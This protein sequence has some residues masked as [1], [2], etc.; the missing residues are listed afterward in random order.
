MSIVNKVKIGIAAMGLTAL[1]SGCAEEINQAANRGGFFT[2]NNADY[3]VIE[4]GI[5]I[6]MGSNTPHFSAPNAIFKT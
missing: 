4:N 6:F 2:S 5:A 3:I 1:L